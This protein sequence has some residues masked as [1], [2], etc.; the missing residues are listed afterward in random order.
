MS[1]ISY[2]KTKEVKMNRTIEIIDRRRKQLII[3]LLIGFGLWYGFFLVPGIYEGIYHFR[4][5]FGPYP[6]IFPFLEKLGIYFYLAGVLI[7]LIF[8][9][10]LLIWLLYKKNLKKDLAL[11]AALNDELVKHNWLKAYRFSFFCTMTLL[12]LLVLCRILDNYMMGRLGMIEGLNVHLLL[13][14]AVISCLAS[15]LYFNR[16]R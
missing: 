4:R 13:Y 10:C 16:E 7:F 6:K 14:T 5:G 3:F 9:V 12:L 2:I 15:F 1:S 8:A 11:R